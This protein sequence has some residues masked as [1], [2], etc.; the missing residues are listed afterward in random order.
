MHEQNNLGHRTFKSHT[1]TLAMYSKGTNYLLSVLFTLSILPGDTS[2][3]VT[4]SIIQYHF[5]PIVIS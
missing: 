1:C 3:S 4:S 2:E 5:K